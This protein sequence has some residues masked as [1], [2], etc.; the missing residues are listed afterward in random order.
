MQHLVLVDDAQA[1]QDFVEQ[2][3]DG[4][5]AEH[6]LLLEVARRD[7]E[8]LEGRTF[9]VVHDHVDGLVLAEEIE[10]A[11]HRG[12]RDLGERAAFL[13]ET[14]QPEPVERELLGRHL[15]RELARPSRG[16]RRGEIFL[17]GDLLPVG[18]DREVHDAE[19][20]RRKPAYD[21]VSAND[22]IGQQGR[23]LDL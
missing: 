1:A 21:A 20:T 23:R 6:L 9:Q 2:R 15:G 5:F 16:E 14:L 3:A 11:D 10:H 17:D 19:A 13:E 7:H 12:M 18:V 22:R 4:R 8:I